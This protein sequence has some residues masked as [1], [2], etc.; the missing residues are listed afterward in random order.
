LELREG[1]VICVENLGLWGLLGVTLDDKLIGYALGKGLLL[2]YADSLGWPLDKWLLW[3]LLLR[4]VDLD[5]GPV[6]NLRL[7]MGWLLL[8]GGKLLLLAH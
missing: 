7:L 3:L 6:D 5:R 8:Q 4:L 1:G 2:D